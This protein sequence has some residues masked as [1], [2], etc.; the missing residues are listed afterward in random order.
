M[1]KDKVEDNEK[2]EEPYAVMKRVRL[3]TKLPVYLPQRVTGELADT[4]AWFKRESAKIGI[5]QCVIQTHFSSAMEVTPDTEKA[6]GRILK[7]GWA[8]TNQEVFTVAASRRGH[9]AKLRKVLNDIGVL[10][11]YNFTVK[12]FRENRALFAT[13]ARSVQ[14]LVEESSIGAIAPRYHARIR[15]FIFNAKE[16]KE[17]IDS[18]RESDEIPFI[19]PDR[20]TIN[21]PGVGKSNTY[22]TI[23]LTDDGRRILRFEFDH[24]RPH[25][26]VIEEMH[27]V[28][29]VESKSIARY[30]R[31]LEAMGEDPKEYES[32]WG[33]SAG[34][35]EE[36][37]PVFEGV[38]ESKE[39]PASPLL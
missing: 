23:G 33:Y 24:T 1:A 16:M 35:M 8:V 39:T 3:G 5:E 4:L 17:Q 18:V 37:S 28:D 29:I 31:Q 2:R 30:L 19:S 38:I 26:K 15:S 12:G 10:P 20:N 22:R 32:I 9:S 25:S 34:E 14:E 36:R 6:V 7:A 13:N 11:Y 21:L 27:H